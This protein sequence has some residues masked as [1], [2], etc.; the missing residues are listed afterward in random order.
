MT[1]KALFIPLHSPQLFCGCVRMLLPVSP[2]QLA[3]CRCSWEPARE[4]GR[5]MYDIIIVNS[6]TLNSSIVL[7][8]QNLMRILKTHHPQESVEQQTYRSVSLESW[9]LEKNGGD[10]IKKVQ[11][12]APIFTC[13]H[14]K[15]T[16]SGVGTLRG[17]GLVRLN[18]LA[19]A[20]QESRVTSDQ[21]AHL[22]TCLTK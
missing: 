2:D 6:A 13:M 21:L 7:D 5:E 9:N 3:D 22:H 17:C 15:L 8:S 16:L 18:G 14:V 19:S 11:C 4:G 1:S 20:R 12:T 10:Y